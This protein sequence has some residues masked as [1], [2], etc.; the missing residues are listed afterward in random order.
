MGL[1]VY[2]QHGMVTGGHGDVVYGG[3]LEE[4]FP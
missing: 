3:I 2:Y 4:S 1:Q